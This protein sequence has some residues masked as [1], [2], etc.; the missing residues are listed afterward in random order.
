MT[1][2]TVLQVV[3]FVA[4]VGC[5]IAALVSNRGSA[6]GART[7]S[8]AASGLLPLTVF[9]TAASLDARDQASRYAMAA[10]AALGLIGLI[11]LVHQAKRRAHHDERR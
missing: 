8:I 11:G 6:S 3:A 2:W 9:C 7:R 5:V 4:L 1:I 10:A